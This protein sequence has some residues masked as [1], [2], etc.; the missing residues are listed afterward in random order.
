MDQQIFKNIGLNQAQADII[1]ILLEQG[2]MKAHAIARALNRSRGIVYKELDELSK[3]NLI[4]KKDKAGQVSRFRAVP[5]KKFEE[6]FRNKET[7][8]KKERHDFMRHL[9]DLT[10]LYNLSSQRPAIK[11]FEDAEGLRQVVFDTLTSQTEVLTFSDSHA[12]RANPELKKINEDYAKLRADKQIKKRI[13]VPETAGKYFTE[14]NSELVRVKLLEKEY[15]P[16]NSTVQIYDNKVSFETTTPE[17]LVAVMIEDENIYK[18][19][20]LLFES[21]WSGDHVRPLGA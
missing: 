18:L 2:E 13:I 17:K 5:P 10:S 16:F 19:H 1:K 8:L 11:F 20:K 14:E 6:F 21:V 15:F 3:L 12:L 9:P 7:A 4:E